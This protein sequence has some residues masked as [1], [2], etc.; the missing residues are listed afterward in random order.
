MDLI[1]GISFLIVFNISGFFSNSTF[2][3]RYPGPEGGGGGG[4]GVFCEK[5]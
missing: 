4:G 2:N 5:L 1:K 3:F